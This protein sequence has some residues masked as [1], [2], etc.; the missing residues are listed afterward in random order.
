MSDGRDLT[1]SDLLAAIRDE[2]A[3]FDALFAAMD[4]ARMMQPVREDGW[5]AKDMLAHVSVWERRMLT[6][7]D[8]W[9]TNG[10]PLRPE[11][12]VAWDAIDLLNERDFERAESRSLADVRSA[13]AGSYARVLA[14]LDTLSDNDLAAC[15]E[16]DEPTWSWMISENTHEHYKEHR[17]EM[18]AWLDSAGATS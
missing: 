18:Q 10:K 9:Q 4:D 3:A 15:P 14:V 12:G 13:A 17:E 7:I 5:T 1:K 11:P 6:W 2:R 16:P 8:R